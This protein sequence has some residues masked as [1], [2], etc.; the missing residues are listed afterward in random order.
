MTS[1]IRHVTI[2]C[3]DPY[4]LAGFWAEA[5]GGAI[6]DEDKPGDP[7]ALVESASVGVLFIRVPEGK[8][9]KNRVH[10][11]LQPQERTRDEEVDRLLALGATLQGDH[12]RPDGTGWVTLHDPEGNEFCVERSAA[13]RSAG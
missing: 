12:R 2:D 13:E 5:L 11:D 3:A 9:A 8:D 7:E 4:T 1:L 10:L 6:T